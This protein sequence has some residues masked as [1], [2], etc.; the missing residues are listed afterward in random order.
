LVK[1]Q[2]GEEILLLIL[3]ATNFYLLILI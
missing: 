1:G 3:I 2:A